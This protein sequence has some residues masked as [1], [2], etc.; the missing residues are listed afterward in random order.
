MK[1]LVLLPLLA[2]AACASE[3]EPMMMAAPPATAH[4][5][6]PG[7]RWKVVDDYAAASVG[8]VQ[9][10]YL[11]R[12]VI[13]ESDW[14]VTADG[15]LCKTPVYGQS[16]GPAAPALENPTQPQAALDPAP[17]QILAVTCGGAPFLTLVSQPDG[18]WLTRMNSW[19][20]KLAKAEEKAPEP[21][22]LAPEPPK[23]AESA[24]D[25]AAPVKP[26]PRV[27]VYLASYKS[28]KGAQAG[29]KALS[30]A[31]PLLAGLSPMIQS[32]D[33]G[34][35]GVW[36]RLYAVAA[37]EADRARICHQIGRRVDECGARNRE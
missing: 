23:P 6:A 19:V 2:V 33:L 35:K 24:P 29:Y 30:K 32:V 31:S 17:R 11:G 22:A 9:S 34:K 13:L 20:L 4:A 7:G 15:R 14:T 18:F 26:D 1:R 28:E 36:V 12:M 10:P 37:S 27:L 25:M 8:V 5:T 21:V 16:E 3:P